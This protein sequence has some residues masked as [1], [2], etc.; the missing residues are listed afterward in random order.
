MNILFDIVI[1]ITLSILISAYV[2]PHTLLTR[3]NN[4]LRFGATEKDGHLITRARYLG[5]ASFLPI[6]LIAVG[7][8]CLLAMRIH[9]GEVEDSLAE[10]IEKIF[11]L[12][13]GLGILYITGL[14]SDISKS[15][16]KI[17]IMA[18]LAA[19]SL[20]PVSGLW[21]N[22][23]FGLF[24]IYE[25]T[26]WVGMPLTVL[27]AMYF[28]ATIGLTDGVEG[29]ASGQCAIS[30]MTVAALGLYCEARLSVFMSCAALGFALTF[31]AYN[32]FRK[33]NTGTFLGLCGS[34]PLGYVICFVIMYL[35]KNKE[36][37]GVND[38]FV[39]AATC[40]MLMPAWD[41]LRVL[42]SRFSDRR[43]LATP[44]RNLLYHKLMRL[45]LKRMGIQIT[46]VLLNLLFMAS[47]LLVIFKESN[48]TEML[49]LDV[50]LFILLHLSMNMIINRRMRRENSMAWEK[51]YGK[52]QWSE[53]ETDAYSHLG[54]E[55]AA[56][57]ILEDEETP[58]AKAHAT[59]M[60]QMTT[61]PFIPDGMNSFERNGKR[62]L[63]CLV[64]GVSLILFSP[65]FLL[66]YILIRLDDGGPA[67]F[68]QERIGRFGRPFY[69]YKFR[70]M[71]MDA[72][73]HGPQ[74]SHTGGEQ[75]DRLTKAGRFL[76]SHHLDELPQLWNVFTGEMAFIGYRP[77]RLFFIQQIAEHDPRY[78]MLYQIR[79][80]VTSYATLYNGYT[81]TMEKML[82]RLE[83]DLYYLKH[84]SWWFD[85][86]ILFLTF[87][88]IMG[89]KRF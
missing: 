59:V 11:Q 71:R 31:Y 43:D 36:W 27:L 23:L 47:A 73:K 8:N 77:E 66:C 46:I 63:D 54:L 88:K 58:R 70:S 45:G 84:R 39:L 15:N 29:M 34:W 85:A 40:T 76:R 82:T 6:F 20:F 62:I 79:P 21:L 48:I 33:K 28:T 50:L 25:L 78:Y 7:L 37:H 38:G 12:M 1:P 18:L 60:P 57:H 24:G 80:G 10:Q 17:K 68:R 64:A 19:C 89:G 55:E 67:I 65:L 51:T 30:L 44:D 41:M 69:I 35:Y 83:L 2:M 81:D 14:L 72:E 61:I 5:G 75:D 42:K 87:W 56:L 32:H 4:K 3:F 74:L 53:E 26:P 13:S 52:E 16:R 49:A 9:H 86:K 22:N